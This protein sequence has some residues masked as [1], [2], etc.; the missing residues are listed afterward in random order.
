MFRTPASPG[1]LEHSRLIP[2]RPRPILAHTSGRRGCPCHSPYPEQVLRCLVSGE[3][4]GLSEESRDGEKALGQCSQREE[5]R[6]E[7]WGRFSGRSILGVEA[8]Q[9]KPVSQA[10]GSSSRVIQC[11]R[12]C[13]RVNVCVW[14]HTRECFPL[15]RK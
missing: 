4:G 12:L 11:L 13:V 2:T 14:M 15:S 6:G 9:K 10:Q 1:Q 3:Q 5:A 8:V 7:D